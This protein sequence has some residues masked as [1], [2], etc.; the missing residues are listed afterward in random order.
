MDHGRILAQ[1]RPADL[2]T[3]HVGEEV[4]EL[5]ASGQEEKTQILERLA[6]LGDV[7]VED[8]EDVVFVLGLG[9]HG[10]HVAAELLRQG[11]QARLRRATLEDVFL[12]LTGRGL[13]E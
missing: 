8:V 13:T 12:R 5:Q 3:S 10:P 11:Q 4:L 9:P 6:G 2:V 1:G 7:T